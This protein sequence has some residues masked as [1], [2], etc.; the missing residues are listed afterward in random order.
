MTVWILKN[1]I[2]REEQ[3]RFRVGRS[4][5]H[6]TFVNKTYTYKRFKDYIE[7]LEKRSDN[8][9]PFIFIF[10]YQKTYSKVVVFF[11]RFLKYMFKHHQKYWWGVLVDLVICRWPDTYVKWW[12]R[13][14]VHDKNVEFCTFKLRFVD[15]IDLLFSFEEKGCWITSNTCRSLRTAYFWRDSAKNGL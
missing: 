12:G 10:W 5:L 15:S 6:N 4:C 11:P 8:R 14:T 2:K 13:H 1:R 7:K 9:K 3:S